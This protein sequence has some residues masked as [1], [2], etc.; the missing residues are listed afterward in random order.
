MAQILVVRDPI[1]QQTPIIHTL[2]STSTDEMGEET[3]SPHNIKQTKVFGILMPIIALNDISVDWMDVI[4]FA[5]DGVEAIPMVKFEFKD[6]KGLLKQYSQPGNDNE[7]RIQ[8]LPPVDNTYKKI[9]LT[10][11]VTNINIDNGVVR[12]EATYK[13]SKFTD[14][15][16]KALGQLTTYDLFDKVSTETGLGFASNV[17][18]TED[19]RYMSCQYE[20]YKDLIK[21]EMPKSGS[22]EAHVFDWWIDFWNNLT[23]CDLYDRVNNEDSEDDMQIWTVLDPNSATIQDDP[24]TV[25][26]TA[27]YTNHPDYEGSDLHVSDFEIEN[28]P[29]TTGS[30]NEIALSVYEE[31]KHEYIDHYIA[32]GDIEKNK[33]IKFEYA[34]EVYG[35]YNYLLA[36]KCRQVFLRKVKSEIVVIHTRHPQIGM[37]RGMQCRFVWYD[38]NS[39]DAYS[40]EN[41]TEAGVIEKEDTVLQQMGWLKD[42]Q[43]ESTDIRPMVLN[44]Q[45][46]GQ[47]TCIGQYITYADHQWD[48]WLYLIRPASKRP[49]LIVETD[50]NQTSN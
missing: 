20:S 4:T 22:S 23:L 49:K 10:F 13:L 5:L 44:L 34:G 29:T 2:T 43:T 42:W 8:I 25:L 35:D 36:E 38:N 11:L 21:K 33:F 17:E 32:D 46:S 15:Q 16:F 26:A 7:L 31:N 41:L 50:D 40:R 12:G 3:F 28:A 9:D 6:R 45:V 18:A 1:I 24:E 39:Q 30:G 19:Q 48:C 37:M 47:Y 14:S 27:Y